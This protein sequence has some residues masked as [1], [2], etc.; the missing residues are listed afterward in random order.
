MK[1]LKILKNYNL[2]Q[3]LGI[4]IRTWKTNNS[5]SDERSSNERYDHYLKNKYRYIEFINASKYHNIF[6]CCDNYIEMEDIINKISNKNIIL[7]RHNNNLNDL[8]NDFSEL[9]LCSK[10]NFIL[11][12]LNSTYSELA[13]WY[14][15]CI[16][17]IKII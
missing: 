7:Y 13:W 10:C 4:H 8:Q 15:K 6:M 12:S 5:F 3:C 2:K 9:L 17:N 11:G 1:L 14:S 16:D